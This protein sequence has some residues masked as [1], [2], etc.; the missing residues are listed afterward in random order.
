MVR[1]NMTA[2]AVCNPRVRCDRMK[3][4]VRLFA[5]LRE[6]AGTRAIEI[7]LPEGSTAADVWPALGLGDEPPGLLA[8]RQQ[9]LRAARHACSPT[10]TR[11]R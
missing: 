5:G 7:E 4:A 8:R 9:E 11:S 6:L 10:A 2:P 3:V 1:C